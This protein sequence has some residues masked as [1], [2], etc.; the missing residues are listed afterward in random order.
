MVSYRC[1]NLKKKSCVLVTS[2]LKFN[3][4]FCNFRIYACGVHKAYFYWPAPYIMAVVGYF[5]ITVLLTSQ[6]ASLEISGNKIQMR[7]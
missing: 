6:C 7:Q 2:T 1:D 3:L 5:Y 4:E